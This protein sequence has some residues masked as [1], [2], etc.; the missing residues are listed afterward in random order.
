MTN[1]EPHPNAHV[2]Q[3]LV[4]ALNQNTRELTS[5]QTARAS[6]MVARAKYIADLAANDQR[7]AELADQKA[8]IIDAMTIFAPPLTDDE[9]EALKQTPGA[10]D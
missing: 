3:M 4:N 8:A 1:H 5:A 2:N 6:L 7:F 10:I 9:I